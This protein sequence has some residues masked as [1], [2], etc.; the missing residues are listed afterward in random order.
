MESLPKSRSLLLHPQSLYLLPMLLSTYRP[1]RILASS[2]QRHTQRRSAPHVRAPH[3]P[4]EQHT[5]HKN[6]Y[7]P[8]NFNPYGNVT[9]NRD[10]HARHT[11]R[12]SLGGGRGDGSGKRGIRPYGSGQ[13]QLFRKV[14]F[15][16]HRSYVFHFGQTKIYYFIKYD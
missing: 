15:M 14:N 7:P 10:C 3:I 2:S 1:R 13:V 16:L 4:H 6:C 12:H 11:P 9:Y 5:A 8:N